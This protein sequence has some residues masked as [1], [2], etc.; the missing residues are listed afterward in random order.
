MSTSKQAD[1]AKTLIDLEQQR[2]SAMMNGDT[3]RLRELLHRDLIHVH[4]KG[5]VDGFDSYFSTGGFNVR[6]QRVER[7][8]LVVRVTGNSALMTG[9][10][11]LVG[12]RKNGTGTVTID[13][14]VMQVWVKEGERWQQLA[15]Q[16]TPTEMSV[17]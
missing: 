2:C 11:M 17:A 4:A 10:Q 16:T 12:V 7:S 5:Q 1:D 6:Y 15:F 8:E 3:E 14:R 9:R 13:S